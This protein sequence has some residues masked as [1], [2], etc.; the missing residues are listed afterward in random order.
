MKKLAA[1]AVVA[2]LSFYGYIGIQAGKALQNKTEQHQKMMDE[3][4]RY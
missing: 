3:V 1:V 4:S 2:V